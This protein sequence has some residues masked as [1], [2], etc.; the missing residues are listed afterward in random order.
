MVALKKKLGLA[1]MHD[2]HPRRPLPWRIFFMPLRPFPG[3]ADT[4]ILLLVKTVGGG[5]DVFLKIFSFFRICSTEDYV[6]QFEQVMQSFPLQE[7][8]I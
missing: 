3:V 1:D 6:V 7:A 5:L 8:D 4:K 2:V